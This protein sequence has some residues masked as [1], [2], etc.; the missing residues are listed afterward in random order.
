[1]FQ[2]PSLELIDRLDQVSNQLGVL[3]RHFQSYIRII[4]RTIEPP[5]A[6]IASLNN[7]QVITKASQE[8]IN[9]EIGSMPIVTEQS[10]LLGVSLSSAARVRFERLKDMIDLY[11]L[12]EVKDYL[13]QKD[14]LQQMVCLHPHDSGCR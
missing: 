2:Q 4:E 6:T 1:M 10:S 14:S 9:G 11:A 7:S 12:S 8:S 13:H 3:K 5:T